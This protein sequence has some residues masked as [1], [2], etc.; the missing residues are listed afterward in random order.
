M[1]RGGGHSLSSAGTGFP[2]GSVQL[3]LCL[4]RVWLN[5][6]TAGHLCWVGRRWLHCRFPWALQELV[7]AAQES[8][9]ANL[10]LASSTAHFTGWFSSPN[11]AGTQAAS[12]LHL[13]LVLFRFCLLPTGKPKHC[14]DFFVLGLFASVI[15]EALLGA[16]LP[17][18]CSGG[19]TQHF[20]CSLPL[21]P[22]SCSDTE[23]PRSL[24]ESTEIVAVLQSATLLTFLPLLFLHLVVNWLEFCICCVF[25]LSRLFQ[26]PITLGNQE[27]TDTDQTAQPPG[28]VPCFMGCADGCSYAPLLCTHFASLPSIS[29]EKQSSFVQY[30]CTWLQEETH[31]GLAQPPSTQSHGGSHCFD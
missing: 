27:L 12:L 25:A 24:S 6:S 15:S 10:S 7:A 17:I 29:T 9:W 18:S 5:C 14:S 3:E 4:T 1:E 21:Q 2:G 16:L 19:R 20:K 28:G 8:C 13:Q 23:D 31:Y 22:Q 11:P 30:S 26:L